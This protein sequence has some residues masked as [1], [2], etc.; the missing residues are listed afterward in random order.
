VVQR[1]LN[2][3]A[4]FLQA[5]VIARTAFY[6][7]WASGDTSVGLDQ[8]RIATLCE[9]YGRP[10]DTDVAVTAYRSALLR[11]TRPVT[12]AEDLLQHLAGSHQLGIVTNAYD[13]KAQR[14]RIAATG[15]D[16]WVHAVV[17]AVEVGYFKPD[18]RIMAAAADTLGV[19]P[20]ECV[21]VG[22]SHEFD[23]AAADAAGMRP[24][25]VG[26]EAPSIEVPCFS[27]LTDLRQ[28]LTGSSS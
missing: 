5:S 16:R 22:D 7:A 24:V 27:S 21:Y 15:L 6:R 8:T 1:R 25:Y 9:H 13:A 23:V 20:S 3:T 2:S 10:E 11:E 17:V 19:A 12:G 28:A 26:C 18:P 14:A 4:Q